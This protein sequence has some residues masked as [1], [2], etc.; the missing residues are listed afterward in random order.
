MIRA[1]SWSGGLPG[2][3]VLDHLTIGD[4]VYAGLRERGSGF[5][6]EAYGDR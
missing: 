2:L 4:G 1:L 3:Q 6:G 5:E